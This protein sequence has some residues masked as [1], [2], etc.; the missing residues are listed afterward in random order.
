[1][2]S[3][4][5]TVAITIL[6]LLMV[7]VIYTAVFQFFY[8]WMR[9]G[10]MFPY[11]DF[12]ALA[13]QYGRNI[14][15]LTILW[16][17]NYAIVYKVNIN[18]GRVFDIVGQFC[19]SILLLVIINLAFT[20]SWR[21]PVDWAGTFFNQFLIFLLC[22]LT[23]HNTAV[24]NAMQRQLDTERKMSSYQLTTLLMQVK[25][26][27]LFNSLNI[28]YS[29]VAIDV[30]KSQKF[31]TSL[32][33]IYQYALEKH[34]GNTVNLEEELQF[35]REYVSIL[36][37]RFDTKFEVQFINPEPYMHRRLMPFTLQLLIE[38]AVKHNA[39]TR[40]KKLCVRVLFQENGIEVS[41]PI[42]P[43]A[44][45]KK[46]K[47]KEFGMHY[48]RSLYEAHGGHIDVN[49]DKETYTVTIS[50]IAR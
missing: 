7:S 38:N 44:I 17:S 35:T 34:E 15:P 37:L 36:Q 5:K 11:E 28:L 49:S 10:I 50:Y 30:A 47:D 18:R 12:R 31:I 16:L 1:M 3:K 20:W 40:S 32:S 4:Y 22:Q 14:G 13:I 6:K 24:K 43:L 42:I 39:I 27:F 8:S 2:I 46:A 29:L 48:L 25:P 45:P 21:L 9:Y 23:A 19:V 33:R 26:H 41:N